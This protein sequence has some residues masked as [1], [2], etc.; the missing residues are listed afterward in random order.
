MRFCLLY[1]SSSG[2]FGAFVTNLLSLFKSDEVTIVK[3]TRGKQSFDATCEGT[4]T[5][6][7]SLRRRRLVWPLLFARFKRRVARLCNR[8]KER[9][10][11][12]QLGIADSVFRCTKRIDLTDFDVVIS[13]E[14]I[15]CNYFLAHNVLAKVK[16]GYVHPDYKMAGFSPYIDQIFFKKLDYVFATS[17]AGSKSLRKALPTLQKR[18]LAMPNPINAEKVISNANSKTSF[19]PNP[20]ITNIVTVCRLDNNSK[21]LDRLVLLAASLKDRGHSF[22]WRIIGD[23]PYKNQLIG[24]IEEYGLQNDVLL[25]GHMDNPLPYVKKSDLFVLQSYYEGYPYS[26]CES[27]IVATPVFVTDYPAASEQVRPTVNGWIAKND[28]DSILATL[29]SIL[30]DKTALQI[31][32]ERARLESMAF[33]CNGE[34]FIS[35]IRSIVTKQKAIHIP[36]AASVDEIKNGGI[37][38]KSAD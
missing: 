26:V 15:L 32:R 8:A 14:E 18:I 2:G 5:T 33:K 4:K 21:A 28:F 38:E 16:I 37:H 12:Y 6:T 10:F 27:L 22:C 31:I 24:L 7:L 17:H 9:L 23:G 34:L 1:S 20:V 30:G 19:H 3:I 11:D 29:D 25:L 13:T 35:T 36:I